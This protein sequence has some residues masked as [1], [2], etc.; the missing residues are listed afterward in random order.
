MSDKD[1]QLVNEIRRKVEEAKR[2]AGSSDKAVKTPDLRSPEDV[3]E[4]LDGLYVEYSYQCMSEM[5]PDGCHRLANY[6]ENIRK[7]YKGATDLYKTTCD[8]Y[9]YSRSC[10]T[11]AKNKTLGRG[12]WMTIRDDFYRFCMVCL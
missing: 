8:E 12:E 9:K 3:K 4:Y 11:Y 5:R 10:S 6:L 1:A 7:D 2:S